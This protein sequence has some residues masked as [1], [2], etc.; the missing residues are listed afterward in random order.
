MKGH[1]GLSPLLRDRGFLYL[2]GGSFLSLLAPWCQRTAVLIWV[3]QLT[4]SGVG[5]SLVGLAEALP[6]LVMAPI[7]GVFVDRWDRSR[8]MTSVVLVQAALMLPLLLVRDASGIP[9]ILVVTLLINAASQF[10]QPAAAAALP[11]VVGEAAVGE[12]N[13][14]LQISNSVVPIIG[15]GAAGL[16]FAAAGP[17]WLVAVIAA[18]YLVATLPLLRVPAHHAG[19]TGKGATSFASEMRDGLAYVRGS[20]LLL[21]LTLVAFVA[22]LGVGGLSVL[23]VVF[24]TRALGQPSETVG[25]LLSATGFGQL[26]GGILI[27]ALTRRV[28]SRYHLVLGFSVL[29]SGAFTFFYALAPTLPAAV[30]ILFGAGTIFPSIMVAFTTMIQ[31]SVEDRY[32]G[33]VMSLV[34]TAM[35]VAILTSLA[36]SGTLADLLGVRNVIGA[37]GAVL[38]LAG[39]ISLALIRTTPPA[40]ASGA[41]DADTSPAPASPGVAPLADEPA[42][43]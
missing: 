39:A 6:L 32:R 1:T 38:M 34:S 24:V 23:D 16:L 42:A 18:V 13:G 31:L 14:L 2:L 27:F 41:G 43:G 11:A 37:G 4:G 26:V 35:S 25:V 3:Y 17:H 5:V 20:R 12:A 29:L 9:I 40:A 19:G 21:L 8:T 28:A 7:A 33:R 36:I 10:F 15:P 30:A 22:M